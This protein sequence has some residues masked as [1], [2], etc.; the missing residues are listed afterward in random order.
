MDFVS[1]QGNLKKLSKIFISKY[2]FSLKLFVTLFGK[3]K[4]STFRRETSTKQDTCF[5]C[6]PLNLD[7]VKVQL[8]L[9]FPDIFHSLCTQTQDNIRLTTSTGSLVLSLFASLVLQRWPSTHRKSI[10][11]LHKGFAPSQSPAL[12]RSCAVHGG[13]YRGTG[14]SLILQTHSSHVLSHFQVSTTTSLQ[15]LGDENPPLCQLITVLEP[16][17][18]L[19]ERKRSWQSFLLVPTHLPKCH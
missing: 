14:S 18:S 10:A 11:C 12:V 17:W 5:I 4:G 15:L 1:S 3:K 6:H 8:P 16:S 2:L 7:G 19:R 9:H 13:R